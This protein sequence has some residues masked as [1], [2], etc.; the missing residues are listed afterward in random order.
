MHLLSKTKTPANY[1]LIAI[2]LLVFLYEVFLGANGKLTEF[3]SDFGFSLSN[4]LDGKIWTFIT[5]I[6]I[7]ADPQ[8]IVLNLLALFF[9]GRVVEEELGWKKYL[10]IFFATGIL[11]NLVPAW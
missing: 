8:H 4:I 1:V 11:G 9:F 7:H 5:S 3:F 2:I 10:L 6:F